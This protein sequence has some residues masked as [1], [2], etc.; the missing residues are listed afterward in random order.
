[1][2]VASAGYRVAIFGQHIITC[3]ASPVN[4]DWIAGNKIDASGGAGQENFMDFAITCFMDRN[5]N[6]FDDKAIS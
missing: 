4:T 5:R 1:M 2:Q 6:I 3:P